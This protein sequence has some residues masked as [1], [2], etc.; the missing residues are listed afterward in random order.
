MD[1]DEV[2]SAVTYTHVTSERRTMTMG[3]LYLE[4]EG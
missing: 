2:F 4:I 1:Q 3:C